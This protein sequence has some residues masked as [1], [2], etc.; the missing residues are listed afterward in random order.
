MRSVRDSSPFLFTACLLVGLRTIASQDNSSL[1]IALY[2]HAKQELGAALIHTPLPLESVLALLLISTWNLTPQKFG[3][4]I[5]SWLLSG[6]AIMHG[7]LCFDSD[8][9]FMEEG[10]PEQEQAAQQLR[11]WNRLCLTHLR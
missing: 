1:E 6:M 8:V 2:E 3:N 7:M 5:D 10:N 9:P 4:Y 11:T